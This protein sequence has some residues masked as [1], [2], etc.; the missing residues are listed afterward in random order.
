MSPD[1]GNTVR[2]TVPPPVRAAGLFVFAAL[3]AFGGSPDFQKMIDDAALAGGGVV[4][5]PAGRHV[6]KGLLLKSNVELHLEKGAVLEGSTNAA[7]YVKAVLPY[8]EGDWMAVVMA[9]GVENVAVTGEGEIFGNGTAWPLPEGYGGNQ[10]GRRPRG[11]AFLGCRRITLSDFTLRD[12]ACW[13]IVLKCCDGVTARRVKISS[14]A[15]INNDGF[16]VEARNV[17]IEDCDVESGD[18]SFCLKSNDPGF[19][20]ENVVIR[21]CIGRTFCNPYKLGTASHGVMRNVLVEDCR[22]DLPQRYFMDTRFGRNRKMYAND[23]RNESN[24]LLAD[25]ENGVGHAG[26][27][28]E[29]VDGGIVE[30]VVFRDMEVAGVAVPIFIRGGTRS[31]R[32]C[33]T[34]P[35]DKHV[36]RDILVENVRGRWASAIANSVSGVEGCRVRNVTFRNVRLHGPGVGDC[37]A[38]K[39]RPVPE[40]AGAY[41][42]A[43]MFKCML[44]AYGLWAR[45]VDGLVLDGVSFALDDGTT[46][47]RDAVVTDDVTGFVQK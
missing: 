35:N 12:A 34:P 25:R 17:L 1:L 29:C 7:D 19:A 33:G 27:A 38:E 15:N 39:T 16:D 3:A 6:T 23:H 43:N 36:I 14:Q 41:P 44:P 32:D 2:N 10:E 11:L 18:D 22:S 4:T 40:K 30:N 28:I 20:V 45:H 31:G 47:S 24:M 9:I 37:V 13:G 21:R 26:I 5:V 42:E 8:S 46:D